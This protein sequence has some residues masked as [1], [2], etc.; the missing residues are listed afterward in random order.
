MEEKEGDSEEGEMLRV[1]R[2]AGERER[3]E[4]DRG[5]ALDP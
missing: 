4:E 2:Y 1:V 5:R 3:R